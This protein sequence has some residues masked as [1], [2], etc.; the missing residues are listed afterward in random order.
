[1]TKKE[2]DYLMNGA[3]VKKSSWDC[4]ENKV[5]YKFTTF[6]HIIRFNSNHS[7]SLIEWD[8]SGYQVWHGRLSVEI[9]K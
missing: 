9:D 8:L 1:M 3:N 2:W 7:Q 6:G 5:V 4:D